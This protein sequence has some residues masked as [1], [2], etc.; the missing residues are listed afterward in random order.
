MH[1]LVDVHDRVHL[2]AGGMEGDGTS[3]EAVANDD[4][5]MID[6]SAGDDLA[7][8]S[9]QRRA[10]QRTAPALFPGSHRESIWRPCTPIGAVSSGESPKVTPAD[11]HLP[12]SSAEWSGGRWVMA[13]AVDTWNRLAHLITHHAG[14]KHAFGVALALILA[15]AAAGI[16]A[17]P[18]RTWE[19]T[20]TCGVPIL[21]L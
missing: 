10:A 5:W 17:G 11:A 21:T 6:S 12:R 20:V 8:V 7:H 1:R 14:S 19:L 16:S 9:S 13:G 15:W 3:A 18:T 2:S 4:R